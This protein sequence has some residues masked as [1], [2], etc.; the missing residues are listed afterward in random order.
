MR[1]AHR[2]P[3]Q[4]NDLEGHG[5][6]AGSLDGDDHVVPKYGLVGVV[7][8]CELMSFGSDSVSIRLIGSH[9]RPKHARFLVGQSDGRA[10]FS[11]ALAQSDRP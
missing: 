10:I 9:Q 11:S 4:A 6:R 1:F 7:Q 8:T 3:N 2:V 5:P